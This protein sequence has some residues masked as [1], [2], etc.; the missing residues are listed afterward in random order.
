MWLVLGCGKFDCTILQGAG[1]ESV[2][3][4]DWDSGRT[5]MCECREQSAPI[6]A[7]Y[8][9]EEMEQMALLD[10]AQRVWTDAHGTVSD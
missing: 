3:D 7:A 6:L 9:R 10:W 8:S 5:S 1:N 4:A 2:F